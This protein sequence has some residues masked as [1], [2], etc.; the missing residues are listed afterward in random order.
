MEDSIYFNGDRL[1]NATHDFL[2][3]IRGTRTLQMKPNCYV[4]YILKRIDFV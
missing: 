1:D 2:E 4:F 3:E